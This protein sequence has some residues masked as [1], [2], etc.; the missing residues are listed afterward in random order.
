MD[1]ELRTPVLNLSGGAGAYLTFST[2]F[3]VKPTGPRADVDV[4]ADGGT[5]WTNV[6]RATTNIDSRPDFE[7]QTVDL[8]QQAGGQSNVIVRFRYTANASSF[9]VWIVDDVVLEPLTQPA[10]PTD[11][12][13]V[14]GKNNV[15][16]LSWMG[17]APDF[18]IQ[19]W[20]TGP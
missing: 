18:E 10:A 16:N 5:T 3:Y 15:V 13:A 19:G 9:G 1:A 11:L 2:F 17:S 7:T 14:L 4:S 20:F 8:S 6:W 12:T